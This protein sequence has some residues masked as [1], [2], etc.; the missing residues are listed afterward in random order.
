MIGRQVIDW[1]RRMICSDD[2]VLTDRLLEAVKRDCVW[3]SPDI[4]TNEGGVGD[5]P[6]DRTNNIKL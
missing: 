5:P 6:C 3:V 4:W 1:I 2:K